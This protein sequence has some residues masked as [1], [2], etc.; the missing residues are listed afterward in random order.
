MLHQLNKLHSCTAVTR[1]PARL[2]QLN[3]ALQHRNLTSSRTMASQA[4]SNASSSGQQQQELQPAA[5][6]DPIVQWVVLRRD[7]WTDIGWPLGPVIAQACHASSAAMFTHLDDPLTQQYIAQENIDHMHKVRQ[8]AAASSTF[9]QAA[10]AGDEVHRKQQ[11]SVL[12]L[13]NVRMASGTR[14]PSPAS[15]QS[16]C[17]TTIATET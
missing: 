1:T 9:K 17:S 6:D 2:R 10:V 4:A 12:K 14:C 11:L 15:W 7:L 13:L 5:A 3:N 8:Q 16:S